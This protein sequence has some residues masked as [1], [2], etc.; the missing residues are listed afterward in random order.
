[1]PDLSTRAPQR[2][3]DWKRC[4]PTQGH[5]HQS[6]KL[7]TRCVQ[8]LT[9]QDYWKIPNASCLPTKRDVTLSHACL[10]CPMLILQ[11]VTPLKHEG[12]WREERCMRRSKTSPGL[13]HRS[14]DVAYRI[15]TSTHG[16]RRCI[17]MKAVRTMTHGRGNAR[18][19]HG[20]GFGIDNPRP[21]V[22][23]CHHLKCQNQES[24]NAMSARRH[25]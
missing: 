8:A 4:I 24:G 14:W 17:C 23:P 10:I 22:R 1:M 18:E 5:I 15:R 3:E 11:I 19:R 25:Q 2:V 21:Y 20:D 16:Q 7:T 12:P 13:T 6:Q 9:S